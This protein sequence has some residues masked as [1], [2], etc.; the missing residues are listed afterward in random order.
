MASKFAI[1]GFTDSLRA[2]LRDSGVSVH[3]VLPGGIDT[4]IV[5]RSRFY[6]DDMGRTDRGQIAAEFRSIARTTPE[7][8][9]QVI[10]RGVK[11]GKGRILV[12]R[13]A[14]MLDR[15]TRIAPSRYW[16]IISRLQRLARPRVSAQESLE[17]L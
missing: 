8:A 6:V 11:R 16:G 1:R 10:L 12:G 5:N 2:E 13:D 4:N 15:L 9:A 3:C 14:R 7:R 17:Q